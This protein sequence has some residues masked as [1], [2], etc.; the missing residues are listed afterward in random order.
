MPQIDPTLLKSVG[1]FAQWEV[2]DVEFADADSDI[3]VPHKLKPPTPEHIYYIPLRKPQAAD[4]YHDWSASR[5]AWPEGAIRLRSSVANAKVTLL[6]VVL[7]QKR[8]LL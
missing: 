6:L 1:P 3:S 7:H 8:D 5:I 4:I 2:V